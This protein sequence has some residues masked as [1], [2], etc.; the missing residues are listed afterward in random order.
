[1]I[2]NP[3]TLAFTILII[4]ILIL[5]SILI[6]AY[7]AKKHHL[8]E[9][10]LL[11]RVAGFLQIVLVIPMLPSMLG[12]LNNGGRGLLFNIEML[13]H[14]SLGIIVVLLWIVFNLAMFKV[15]KIKARLKKPMW[16]AQVLWIITILIG[17][18]LFYITWL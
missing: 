14:H 11:I 15:I 7:I 18:H 5:I 13:I 10:C 6:G 3:R 12:Y 2:I 17:C 16:I 8:K 9:H 4:Q 1:M